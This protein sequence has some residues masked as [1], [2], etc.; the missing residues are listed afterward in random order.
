MKLSVLDLRYNY[1]AQRFFL[2][3]SLSKKFP[4]TLNIEATNNCNLACV[5]CPRT[6]TNRQLGNIKPSLFKKIIDEMALGR[7]KLWSLW[8]MKD[9]ESLLHPN[10]ADLIAYAKKKNIAKQ[11]EIYTRG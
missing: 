9:G 8:L 4:S 11:M 7:K 1:F 5:F 3:T 2:L 6:M 10:L